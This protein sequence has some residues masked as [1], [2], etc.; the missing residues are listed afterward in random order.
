VAR[1]VVQ[2]RASKPTCWPARVCVRSSDKAY[3]TKRDLQ[4][5]QVLHTGPLSCKQ[6]CKAFACW[7]SLHMHR[8]I[9]LAIGTGPAGPKGC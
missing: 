3:C 4:E 6:C 1:A 5:H 9:P 7:T 8:N 2:R